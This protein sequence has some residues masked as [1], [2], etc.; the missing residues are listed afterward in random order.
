MGGGN[1]LTMMVRGVLICVLFVKD[2][3]TMLITINL[4]NTVQ[5]AVQRWMVMGMVK[6]CYNCTDKCPQ[7]ELAH[8]V[9]V[10]RMYATKAYIALAKKIDNGELVEVVRCKDCKNWMYEYDDVGLC[11]TD[12]PD[13]DGVQRLAHDFCSYGERQ[14]DHGKDQN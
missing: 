7:A 2:E 11:V 10:G 6:D 9:A 5:T 1:L 8:Q 14:D 13:I 4:I 3:C 12:V